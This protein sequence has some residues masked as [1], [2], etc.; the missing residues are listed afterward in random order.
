MQSIVEASQTNSE[1]KKRVD[2]NL[3]LRHLALDKSSFVH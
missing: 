2:S 1:K 3:I